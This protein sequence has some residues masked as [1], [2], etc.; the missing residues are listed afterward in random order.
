MN[1][2]R[3]KKYM[4]KLSI[5]GVKIYVCNLNMKPY[6]RRLDNRSSNIRNESRRKIYER[7]GGKCE[8]CGKPLEYTQMQIHHVVP[9]SMNG[10]NNPHNLMCLC[11]DCHRLI[12]GNPYINQSFIE[13]KLRE[14]PEVREHGRKHLMDEVKEVRKRKMLCKWTIPGISFSVIQ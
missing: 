8:H 7:G 4:L 12:H 11:H 2:E 13:R 1:E 9:V 5:L 3:K 6:L 10:T 14:H